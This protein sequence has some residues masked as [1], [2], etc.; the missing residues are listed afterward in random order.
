MGKQPDFIEDVHSIYTVNG[1]KAY[2]GFEVNRVLFQDKS[3]F[4][5][6]AIYEND[7]LGRVLVLDGIVQVT[8]I[9]EFIYQEMMVH[10][11][12]FSHDNP[13]NVL[14]VGGGDGGI[15]REVMRHKTVKKAV[16]TEIDQ[17]VI[18]ACIKHIPCI[19]NAGDVYKDPKAE[20]IV[21]DAAEYVKNTDIKFD[22]VIVDSTDPV[23]PGEKLFSYEFYENVAKIMSDGAF[24]STQGGV[25]IFQ[26]G[27]I[28]NTLACLK[29]A[30]IKTSCYI[31]AIPTYYG[32]YMTLGFGAKDPNWRLPTLEFLEKR[33]SQTGITTKHYSPAMHCASFVLPPWIE[34]DIS[35]VLEKGGI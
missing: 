26:P 4:Q 10:V 12:L 1:T 27:E 17:M 13:E 16:M 14:I 34:A 28:S 31:A 25:P 11:P 9:D 6:V 18:D 35:T 32:G 19:N 30:K 22:V 24:V 20:L 5:D 2:Q 21:G 15:L 8:E 29:N 23:G 7:A 3:L 33:F